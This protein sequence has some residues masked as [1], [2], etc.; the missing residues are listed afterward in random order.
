LA[1][2]EEATLQWRALLLNKGTQYTTTTTTM[3]WML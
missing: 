1:L 2:S 3:M